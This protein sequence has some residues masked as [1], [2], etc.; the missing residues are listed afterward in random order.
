MSSSNGIYLEY[1]EH[2]YLGA[3]GQNGPLDFYSP[4]FLIGKGGHK[5]INSQPPSL[6]AIHIR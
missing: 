2:I 1:Y 6:G 3:R 5:L 4:Y